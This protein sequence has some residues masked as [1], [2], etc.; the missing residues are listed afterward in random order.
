MVGVG[1]K[2]KVLIGVWGLSGCLSDSP[3]IVGAGADQ[4]FGYY[5]GLTAISGVF[6]SHKKVAVKTDRFFVGLLCTPIKMFCIFVLSIKPR[7]LIGYAK[8]PFGIEFSRGFF[9]KMT[10]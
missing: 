6:L 9:M 10:K 3:T 1:Q 5:Q 4:P 2:T 7:G 8:L